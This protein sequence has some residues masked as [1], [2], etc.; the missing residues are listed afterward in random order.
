VTDA[1]CNYIS[2]NL[3]QVATWLFPFRAICSEGRFIKIVET[4]HR[5]DWRHKRHECEHKSPSLVVEIDFIA[6]N[7]NEKP[8][9]SCG[10]NPLRD[11]W[12]GTHRAKRG[13]TG[14]CAR[15]KIPNWPRSFR[16]IR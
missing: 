1:V 5:K 11:D 6:K 8:Q 16:M 2:S 13:F 3:L 15:K 9:S 7:S 14:F 12:L 4:Q 10:K